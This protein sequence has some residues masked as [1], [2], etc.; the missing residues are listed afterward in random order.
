MTGLIRRARETLTGPTAVN[1][2]VVAGGN[3]VSALASLAATVVVSRSL[4][5]SSYGVF[6]LALGA[7][8]T[9]T[10]L[11]DFGLN[12]GLLR[13]AARLGA[14]GDMNA[15]GRYLRAYAQLKTLLFLAAG[16]AGLALSGWLA[17]SV[18]K[19]P[20]APL[21]RWAVVGA[22]GLNLL[23]CG[24]NLLEAR[25]RFLDVSLVTAGTGLLKLAAVAVLYA[26][27]R[28]TP[29]SSLIAYLFL[30]ASGLAYALWRLPD[31][32]LRPD[33]RG[34]LAPER[35]ELIGF[36]AWIGFVSICS[37]LAAY[38]DVTL[39]NRSL[40]ARA[41]GLYSA[42]YRFASVFVMASFPL[43]SV[44]KARASTFA[45]VGRLEEYLGK[46]KIMAALAG[47]GVLA[48]WLAAP[49]AVRVF[50]GPA[51]EGS[52]PLLRI[53]SIGTALTF[54]SSPFIMAFYAFGRSRS[55][56]I[57]GP[58]NLAV[59]FIALRLLLPRLGTAGAAWAF[60]LTH[61]V[62]F[63][64]VV[65]LVRADLAR[66]QAELPAPHDAPRP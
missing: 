50:L 8:T 52:I 55:L 48:V 1:S 37:S 58:I 29:A 26:A 45:T 21:L 18:I 25:Q 10:T 6:A 51:Y 59:L 17:A 40:D 23:T 36:G 14:A 64:V 65:V 4:G 61:A 44:L 62:L 32:P 54:A 63:A 19:F 49:L 53:L 28:L 2:L 12:E 39:I 66:A 38:L 35:R 20:H 60:S 46:A 9:A 42:A 24:R 41:V 47:A 11:M 57:L 33:D 27:S 5:P 43:A 7:A 13:Y 16:G 34:G 30:P 3:A 31:I 56:A 15:V 22:I